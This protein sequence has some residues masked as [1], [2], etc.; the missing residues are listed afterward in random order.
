MGL[1]AIR[2]TQAVMRSTLVISD[3]KMTSPAAPLDSRNRK[4]NWKRRLDLI[5]VFIRGLMDGRLVDL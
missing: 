3:I 4:N 2:N 1:T 5:H